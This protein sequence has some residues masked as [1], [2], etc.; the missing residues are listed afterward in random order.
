MM[1]APSASTTIP[2]W[3]TD[4][5]TST[6]AF[7]DRWHREKRTAVLLVPSVV[8]PGIVHNVLINPEHPEARLLRASDVREVVWDERLFRPTE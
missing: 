5:L 7:G 6:R 4:D 1:A 2:D 3:N 8:T